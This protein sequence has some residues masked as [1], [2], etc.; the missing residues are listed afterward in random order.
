MLV[1]TRSRSNQTEIMDDL[2][3]TGD[4]LGDTLKRLA[5]INRLLGGNRV[6]VSGVEQLVKDTSK[7]DEVTIIDLGCG[8][9]DMLRILADYGRKSGRRFKL[10]GLDANAFT[11]GYARAQ[12]ED[13]PEITYQ[14]MDVF[15]DRMRDFDY[16]I[17]LATLFFHHLNNKEI[18]ELLG[19]LITKAKKG[20][21]IN[22][23]HRSKM[24]YYLFKGYSLFIRNAMIKNDGAISI[25]RAFKRFDLE[26]F[27]N[28]LG[29]NSE[30]RWKWA[31]RYQWVIKTI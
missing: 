16:D 24:A 18:E 1:D 22:D 30:I 23:L 13:Y 6:T 7:T 10:I 17:V 3:M 31:F 28:K 21:V 29:L 4:L 15:S 27:S 2:E 25:L 12:S 20:M 11:I 14:E 5:T 9:G 8:D 19:L 26:R